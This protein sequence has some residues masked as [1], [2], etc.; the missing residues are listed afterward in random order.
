MSLKIKI[1]LSILVG[2]VLLATL[3]TILGVTT[4]PLAVILMTV[5]LVSFTGSVYLQVQS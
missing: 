2:L 1:L 3:L 5:L 4:L